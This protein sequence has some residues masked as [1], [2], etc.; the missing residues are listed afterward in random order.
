[1]I[2]SD[3]PERGFAGEHATDLAAINLALDSEK[4]VSQHT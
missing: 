3:G 4:R 2:S 1:M